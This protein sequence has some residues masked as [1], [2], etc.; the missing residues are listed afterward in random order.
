MIV[1]TDLGLNFSNLHLEVENCCSPQG[2][3]T[4][5]QGSYYFDS[6]DPSDSY[7]NLWFSDQ[8]IGEKFLI[9]N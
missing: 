4:E 7:M 5:S 6:D 1:N 8:T 2:C 9:A 3:E